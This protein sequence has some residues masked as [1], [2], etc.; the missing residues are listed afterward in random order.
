MTVETLRHHTSLTLAMVA[1]RRSDAKELA[2]G[3]V[4]DDGETT[5][6]LPT[7]KRTY[8]CYWSIELGHRAY[9]ATTMAARWCTAWWHDG[10]SAI[11]VLG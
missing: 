6:V 10:G 3:E 7:N 8:L 2:D 5:N 9:A 11:L 1:R 4:T